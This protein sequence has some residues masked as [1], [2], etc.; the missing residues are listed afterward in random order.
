VLALCS[1]LRS[2]NIGGTHLVCDVSR[3]QKGLHRPIELPD[4]N[5]LRGTLAQIKGKVNNSHLFLKYLP[6]DS[7]AHKTLASLMMYLLLQH[8]VLLDPDCTIAIQF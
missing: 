2:L 8:L 3:F 4:S 7:S 5:T 6:G 1:G